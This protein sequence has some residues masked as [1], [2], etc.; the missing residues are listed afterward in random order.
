MPNSPFREFYCYKTDAKNDISCS[1]CI[2]EYQTGEAARRGEYNRHPRHFFSGTARK[3]PV[4]TFPAEAMAS[5]P[6][7]KGAVLSE[8]TGHGPMQQRRC[9]LKTTDHIGRFLGTR[10]GA[11]ISLSLSSQRSD[12]MRRAS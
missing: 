2:A 7:R 4:I 11:A 8:Q 5:P 1:F 10:A 3:E 6:D 12:A 9:V